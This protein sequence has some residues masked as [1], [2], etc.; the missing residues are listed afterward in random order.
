[1]KVQ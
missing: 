1:H